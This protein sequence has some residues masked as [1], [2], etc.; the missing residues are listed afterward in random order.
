MLFRSY[1][2][3][4]HAIVLVVRAWR[5]T[6]SGVI[7]WGREINAHSVSTRHRNVT[8]GGA[9]ID[10]FTV[11]VLTDI[12]PPEYHK[13]N[14]AR[15]DGTFLSVNNKKRRCKVGLPAKILKGKFAC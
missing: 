13:F 11:H 7:V 6:D 15:T 8:C 2:A 3:K 5:P 10:A 1:G 12:V 9:E 4:P 14:V